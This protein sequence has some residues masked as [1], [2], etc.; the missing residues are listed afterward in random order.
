MKAFVC[1][2]KFLAALSQVESGNNPR[3]VGDGGLAVGRYQ[4]HEGVIADVNRHWKTDYVWP[5]DVYGP[6]NDAKAEAIVRR[7]LTIYCTSKRLG[8]EPMEQDAARIWNGGPNGFRR[9]ATEKYWD[10][11][12]SVLDKRP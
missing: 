2:I 12:K 7:Y 8:H 5:R 3:A 6:Q 11:V 9:E 1:T 4:I 10:K